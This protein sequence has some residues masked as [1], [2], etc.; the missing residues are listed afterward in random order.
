MDIQSLKLRVIQEHYP[1]SDELEEANNIFNKI[2]GFIKEEYGLE[3]HF[4]G[5][6]GRGTS[7]KNDKDID[8]FM[9]FPE[10]TSRKELEE[11]GLEIGKK[12]FEEFSGK[13]HA[14]YAEHPYTKGEIKGHEVEIVKK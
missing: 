10:S 13:H 6:A 11:K 12:A 4:A 2:S 8:I 7:R 14:E 1:D 3:S 9:L 5:S